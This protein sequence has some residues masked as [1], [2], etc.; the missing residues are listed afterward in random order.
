MAG[1]VT[2][3]ALAEGTVALGLVVDAGA[4]ELLLGATEVP[5]MAEVCGA[6]VPGVC[7]SQPAIKNSAAAA[8]VTPSG[9]IVMVP[10]VELLLT[11]GE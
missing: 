10:P 5:G 4:L 8:Q 11:R 9:R 3:A 2:V 1:L 6:A 7:S